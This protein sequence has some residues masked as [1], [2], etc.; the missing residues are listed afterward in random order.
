MKRSSQWSVDPKVGI[1]SGSGSGQVMAWARDIKTG[2]PVYILEL[3]VTRTGSNCDC[4]CPSCNLPLTAVNAAKSEYIKRPHFRHPDGAEKSDC[5]YLSA[6]L[7]ALQL[8]R[9]Q[10]FILL[11]KRQQSGNSVGLS[12]TQYEA[13][14]DH[15]AKRVAIRNFDFSDKA[16]A[17]LTLDD[18]RRLRFTLFGDGASTTDSGDLIANIR[19]NC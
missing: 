18:G 1:H 5:M 16:S 19:L 13:W 4:E 14:V 17:V 6:R 12:G 7:A 15:P 10:G 8:L 3:D 2:E 11:P 9:D